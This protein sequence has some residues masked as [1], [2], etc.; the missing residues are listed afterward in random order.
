MSNL[1]RLSR[2]LEIKRDAINLKKSLKRLF[3]PTMGASGWMQNCPIAALH[4]FLGRK[5]RAK[6]HLL[7]HRCH[8]DARIFNHNR[9][10]TWITI[11]APT[12][13]VPVVHALSCPLIHSNPLVRLINR[14]WPECAWP[15]MQ[16]TDARR[17]WTVRS[18]RRMKL[19]HIL[20]LA[21]DPRATTSFT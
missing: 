21:T 4:A 2:R 19:I 12:L 14:T 17:W 6:L 18:D 9:P 20:L 5:K 15:C 3:S 11:L 10:L 7:L 16:R 1:K 8:T 13:S